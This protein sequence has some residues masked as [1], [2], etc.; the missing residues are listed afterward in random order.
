MV[1]FYLK[2]PEPDPMLLCRSDVLSETPQTMNNSPPHL[3]K[4]QYQVQEEPHAKSSSECDVVDEFYHAQAQPKANLCRSSTQ[5]KLL[6][7]V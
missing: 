3:L 4:P 2:E 7:Q 5:T 6:K 1:R